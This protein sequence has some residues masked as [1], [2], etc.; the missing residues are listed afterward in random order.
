[1]CGFIYWQ[2]ILNRIYFLTC[3]AGEPQF[4]DLQ[5]SGLLKHLSNLGNITEIEWK[6]NEVKKLAQLFEVD[7][8]FFLLAKIIQS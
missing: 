7:R 5:V 8:N 4:S 6:T 1:M 3:N 2:D